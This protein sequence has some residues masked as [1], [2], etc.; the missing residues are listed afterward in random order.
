MERN[1]LK[2]LYIHFLFMQ[3][4][5]KSNNRTHSRAVVHD[6]APCPHPNRGRA[7]I[8]Y[9]RA[10]AILLKPYRKHVE[11]IPHVRSDIHSE[12]V[13]NKYVV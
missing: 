8:R 1:Y 10:H 9:T 11:G 13:L 3:L 6:T 4:L 12:R 2:S 5:Y 7:D